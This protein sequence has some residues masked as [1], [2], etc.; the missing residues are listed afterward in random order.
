VGR[1]LGSATG[2]DPALR[3][4]AATAGEV[5][6]QA[7]AGGPCEEEKEEEGGSAMV[8]VRELALGA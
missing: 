2:A 8:V 3:P 5:L 6:T 4:T 1:M 7:L